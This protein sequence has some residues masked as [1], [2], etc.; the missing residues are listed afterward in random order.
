MF[1]PYTPPPRWLHLCSR[2]SWLKMFTWTTRRWT[3]TPHHQPEISCQAQ[4]C[5]H[6]CLAQNHLK[7]HHH[8][9]KPKCDNACPL[10][11]SLRW[12]P[13][14]LG[15]GQKSSSCVQVPGPW[16]PVSSP[17]SPHCWCS[18]H[19]HHLSLHLVQANPLSPTLSP[20]HVLFPLPEIL[21]PPFAC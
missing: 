13:L 15:P 11:N 20:L 3:S 12:P 8:F 9:L 14:L 4:A 5:V 19:S 7:C 10:L 2:F 1:L 21:F 18:L 16:V 17:A 6:K